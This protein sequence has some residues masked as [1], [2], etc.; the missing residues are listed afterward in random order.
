MDRAALLR[1]LVEPKN[2]L[3]KQ[4]RTLL[5]YDGVELSFSDDALESVAEK[6][7][8]RKTGARG[9]RSILESVM[10]DIMYEVPSMTGVERCVVNADVINQDKR[11]LYLFKTEEEI[12]A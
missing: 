3:T 7:A 10:M 9:L 6:A 8:A 4:Y 1:I 5:N 11:P 2:A 12:A